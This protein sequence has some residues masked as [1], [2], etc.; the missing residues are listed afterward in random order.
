MLQIVNYNLTICPPNWYNVYKL[1]N[2]YDYVWRLGVKVKNKL[3]IYFLGLL[4]HAIHKFED[5]N[6]RNTY[7]DT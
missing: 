2:F 7:V 1:K 6:P 5:L 3:E 4:Y